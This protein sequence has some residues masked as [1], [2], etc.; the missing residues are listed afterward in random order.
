M[1]EKGAQRGKR[2]KRHRAARI[3]NCDPTFRSLGYGRIE[4]VE[5]AMR[6]DRSVSDRQDG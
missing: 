2:R 6:R 4:L 5:E 1:F 3:P